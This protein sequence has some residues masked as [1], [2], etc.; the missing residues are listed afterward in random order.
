VIL[1]SVLRLAGAPLENLCEGLLLM[2]VV[3][4]R[5]I[6]MI[7]EGMG[8]GKRLSVGGLCRLR[9]R[10]VMMGRVI[11]W[12]WRRRV[13]PM[14]RVRLVATRLVRATLVHRWVT[15]MMRWRRIIL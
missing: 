9:R 7:S 3:L 14:G 11:G 10:G 6:V 1:E 13:I 12:R 4:K 5:R 8:L 2:L 15:C